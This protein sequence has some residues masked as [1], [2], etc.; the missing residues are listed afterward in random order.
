M[1]DS[2]S[3]AEAMPLAP[4]DLVFAR[5]I[6]D[7]FGLERF[8]PR[9]YHRRICGGRA[10]TSEQDAAEIYQTLAAHRRVVMPDPGI[11]GDDGWCLNPAV[12]PAIRARRRPGR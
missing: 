10:R 5:R 6:F 11:R 2:A 7:T 1:P 12:L 9:N 8:T 4:E 3:A